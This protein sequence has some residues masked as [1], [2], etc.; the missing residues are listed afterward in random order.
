MFLKRLT[1]KG[2]K[3]FAEATSLEFEPG[4]TAVVGPNGSGKSNVVDAVTWVLGAQSTRALRSAKME[5]VIFVGTAT[6]P[7]LGRAEVTLTLDNASGRLPVDGAEVTISRTLFRNGESEYAINGAVCRLLDVQE[8]LSDSGV[9]RQQ[10]MIIGQGQLDAV[11]NSRPEDRRA[12]IEE[13]AGVLK[14]RRRKERAERR[15]EATQENL[16]RLGDLVREVRRQMRPLERQAVAARSYADVETEL[17]ATQRYAFATRLDDY[18][19]RRRVLDDQ[20][21]QGALRDQELRQA[22]RTLDARAAAAAIEISSQR[23]ETLASTLGRLQGLAERVRGTSSLIAERQRSARAAVVAA[24]D[25]NVIATLEADAAHLADE[26]IAVDADERALADP[27]ADADDARRALSE[28]EAQFEATWGDSAIASAHI[29]LR[30]SAERLAV[31]TR[32][33]T[34]AEESLGRTQGRLVEL[35]ARLDGARDERARAEADQ[36][37]LHQEVESR[38]R[39]A[40]R[41]RADATAATR[42]RHGADEALREKTSEA[43][44]ARARADAVAH[45]FDELS[46]ASSRAL[47]VDHEGVL[48]A[49]LE[50]IEIDAGAERAVESAVGAAAS[51]VLVRG[52]HEVRRALDTLRRE[53][54]AGAVLPVAGRTASPAVIPTG[55][56]ALRSVVRARADAPDHVNDALDALCA[57]SILAD[58]FDVAIEVAFAHPDLVVVTREGDRL[59]PSG[60]RAASGRSIVTRAAVDDAERV[61]DEAEAVVREARTAVDVADAAVVTSDDR[62]RAAAAALA[63]AERARCTGSIK[64]PITGKPDPKHISTS[65]SERQNLNIRM[66]NRRM[67]R[68]TNAFSKKAENHA[69]MM[70]IYFMH[71]NFVRIHQTLKVTPAMAAGKITISDI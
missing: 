32:T 41:A 57:T 21:H 59:A 24:A 4:V 16:E 17:R 42:R 47:L 62:A 5:D 37:R 60:W 6:R 7:A 12:V 63:D 43:H 14:H 3:S 33:A 67:T 66:G 10:H 35:V 70:S 18:L 48:G 39:D 45:A 51:A 15:L 31:L 40:D 25:E 9:G 30:E 65:Y 71:Y 55:C 1:M 11:L 8:L 20:L 34:S 53:G 22:M 56:V 49:L 29:E 2:F 54:G 44:R 46:G 26:S 61:A 28:A 27:R 38:R 36:P 50:L 19:G 64:M 58:N 13:A 52:E 69:H 68:L 23:E